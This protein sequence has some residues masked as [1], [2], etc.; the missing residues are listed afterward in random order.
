MNA[1]WTVARRELKALFDQPTGYILL[2]VFLAINDFLFFRQA[3]LFRVAS[4]RP[5]LDL[6]PWMFLFFIPAVTMRSFAED[7]RTGTI[8]V[9]LAQPIGSPISPP[10]RHGRAVSLSS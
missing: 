9:V 6:L 1:I 7:I 10:D 3:Y 5:M 2:V 8:E 4:L